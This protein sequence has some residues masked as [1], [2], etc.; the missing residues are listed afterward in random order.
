MVLWAVTF[1]GGV[2]ENQAMANGTKSANIG[3]FGDWVAAR[4]RK[5]VHYLA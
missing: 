3:G 2:Y 5:S 1:S 4:H